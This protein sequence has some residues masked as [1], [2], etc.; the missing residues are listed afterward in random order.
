MLRP[1]RNSHSWSDNSCSSSEFGRGLGGSGEKCECESGGL[2]CRSPR[3]RG[4]VEDDED[5]EFGLK[6]VCLRAVKEERR[7]SNKPFDELSVEI[8]FSMLVCERVMVD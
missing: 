8:R 5:V 7:E 4:G 1:V 6:L 2:V 3:P